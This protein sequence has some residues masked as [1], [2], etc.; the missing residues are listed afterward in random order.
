[1]KKTEKRGGSR[2]GAGRKTLPQSEKRKMV[3]LKLHPRAVLELARRSQLC[4]S[5]GA[6]V[7]HLLGFERENCCEDFSI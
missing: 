4:G 2:V 3:S 5:Q 7:E 6:F 1:M